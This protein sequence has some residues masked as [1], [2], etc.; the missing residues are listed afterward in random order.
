MGTK[1]R[2]LRRDYVI[3]SYDFYNL[4]VLVFLSPLSDVSA[5]NNLETSQGATNIKH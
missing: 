1:E 3:E 5:A 2:L 4:V